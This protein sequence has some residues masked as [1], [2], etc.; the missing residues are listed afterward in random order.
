MNGTA[1]RGRRHN[2]EQVHGAPPRRVRRRVRLRRPRWTK[3]AEQSD[4]ARRA[5]VWGTKHD[6]FDDGGPGVDVT[7]SQET[8]ER[9]TP[10]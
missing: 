1:G 10:E 4:R 9:P 3:R 2:H 6:V 8:V 7:V 5:A